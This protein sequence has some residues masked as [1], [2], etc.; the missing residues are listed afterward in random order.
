MLLQ[1]AQTKLERARKAK[2][3][4]YDLKG[5]SSPTNMKA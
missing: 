3:T 1:A 2:I 5:Q 4:H